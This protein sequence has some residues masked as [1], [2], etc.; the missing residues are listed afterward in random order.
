M[1]KPPKIAK[2]ATTTYKYISREAV[3]KNCFPAQARL[4]GFLKA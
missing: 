4:K 3:F 2:T 1:P